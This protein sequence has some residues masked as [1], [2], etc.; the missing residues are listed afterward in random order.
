MTVVPSRLPLRF[1]AT[2]P[3]GSPV[4]A[5]RTELRWVEKPVNRPS[6]PPRV[7]WSACN[8]AP[9]ALVVDSMNRIMRTWKGT[10]TTDVGPHG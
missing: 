8:R 4:T 9:A 1:G 5:P 7:Y 10:P 6:Q 2:C 3:P